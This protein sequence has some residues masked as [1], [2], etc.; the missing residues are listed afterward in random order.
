MNLPT[1][2][3]SSQPTVKRF[4]LDEYHRLGELGF[5]DQNDRIELIRGELV[6]MAAKGTSH[7]VCLTKLIRELPKLLSDRATVRCQSPIILSDSEP[8]PDFTIVKNRSDDY[9][10]SHPSS[11]DILLLIEIS[12][13]SLTYDQETKLSLY[14]EHNIQ[15]YWI[16]N[17]L[18]NVLE[19]YSQPYQKPQGFGYRVRQVLLANEGTTLPH[20]PD[21]VLDLSKTFP[22]KLT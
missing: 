12:D 17:L 5:F 6:T 16:F 20:F 4:T 9:L 1:T 11:E 21:L 10:D 15:D 19:I 3:S 22:T 2:T 18:E 8:E 7:E 14:A 13:S